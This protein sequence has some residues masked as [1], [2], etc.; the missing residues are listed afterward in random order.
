VRVKACVAVADLE[1]VTLAVND[2][3]PEAVG[4]P[5]SKPLVLSSVMPAGSEPAEIAQVY[6]VVPPVAPRAAPYPEPVFPPGREVVVIVRLPLVAVTVTAAVAFFVLSATLVA[7]TETDVVALTV[8]AV[9]APAV[10]MLP[11]LAVHVTAVL[12]VPVT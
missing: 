2:E 3:V 10:E 11:A 7:V 12:L 5:D 8:G 6:G 4:V 1:S 9:K